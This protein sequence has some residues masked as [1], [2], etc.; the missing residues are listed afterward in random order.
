MMRTKWWSSAQWGPWTAFALGRRARFFDFG[1]V[2]LAILSLLNEGPKHGY[3]LMKEME[4]RSG[5]MYRASPGSI[6]PTLQQLEDEGLVTSK[7]QDGKKV[8]R[9]TEAGRKELERDPQTVRRIWERA[10]HWEDWSQCMGPETFALLGPAA[11]VMKAT[12]RAA[13]R[14][15]SRPEHEER[16]RRILARACR[17]LDELDKA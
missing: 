7:R 5:G 3:Q 8:Y 4:E 14:A 15:R 13:S 11:A 12:L 17:E 16:I 10:E 9:I 1:E 2:R 6:Y